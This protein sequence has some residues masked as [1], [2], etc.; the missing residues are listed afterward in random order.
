MTSNG[1]ARLGGKP[2]KISFENRK[3]HFSMYP[4]LI[5][6]NLSFWYWSWKK[7]NGTFVAQG[8]IKGQERLHKDFLSHF[9]VQKYSKY[10]TYR[11]NVSP[12]NFQ[13]KSTYLVFFCQCR[14][15]IFSPP[16]E[17]GSLNLLLKCYRTNFHSKCR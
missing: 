7:L 15:E 16:E 3:E 6:K 14:P 17:G 8:W 9:T 10:H 4:I 2:P 5:S 13:K 1:V 12:A 11:K